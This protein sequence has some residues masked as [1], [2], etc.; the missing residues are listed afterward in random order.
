MHLMLDLE[1]LSTSP[2]T[3]V[4]SLGAV[5]FDEKTIHR[6]EHITFDV[7]EQLDVYKRH[8][9]VKTV[10]WW[11]DQSVAAKAVFA[12]RDPMSLRGGLRLLDTLLTAQDWEKVQV[13]SNGAS[14][15]L[16]ILHTMYEA[17][18]NDAPWRFY[19]E[20]CYRTMEEL[21]RDVPKPAREG[22]EHNAVDDAVYQAR[23]LQAVWA[24]HA[25]K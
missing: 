17:V 21:Y 24:A 11:I 16:P 8:V 1:T 15:D 12:P 6:T 14:F 18:H 5:V 10:A 19:N 7:Q 25:A 13:W 9:S 4:L 23:H 22:V 3:A 2:N 20:R